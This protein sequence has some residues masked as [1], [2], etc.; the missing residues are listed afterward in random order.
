MRIAC[1][2]STRPELKDAVAESSA[3]VIS[4]LEGAAADLTL[5]F[6]SHHHR[7]QFP[8][9]AAAWQ[10]AVPTR[11][12]LGCSGEAIVAGR[13]EV[14]GGPCLSA[15]TASCPQTELVPFRVEFEPTPDGVVCVGLPE[16]LADQPQRVRAVILLG[17]PFSSA[18]RS[19]LD[20]LGDE[21]PGVP[22]VGGMASGG[23]PDENSLFFGDTAVPHGA[24]GVALLDAP[25][26]ITL[27][28]QGC[29][30]IGSPYIVTKSERNVIYELGGRPAMERLQELYPT[31]SARDQAL[32]EQGLH[33]GLAM[34]EYQDRFGRGDFLVSN[35]MGAHR[36]SGAILLGNLV[37]TGQ[38]VQFHVRD[39]E[40]ADEDLQHLLEALP[41]P[42]SLAGGLLFTC[43]GRGTRM[44]STPDHDAAAIQRQL[45]PLPLA[46]LFAAGEIG[47]VG[48]R[49]YVH[50]FTA[51]VALFER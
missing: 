21:L 12:L 20:R 50:G 18:P 41:K 26:V 19:V 49:N 9:V 36:E 31:L 34:S 33:V 28:S 4:G 17:E 2:A 30:P 23:G 40:T 7:G 46:G 1:G 8:A 11:C 43:N 5:L 32:I 39:A 35:V 45:G 47:P 25:R 14:E 51:S 27:V 29:K 24:V 44:F 22:V 16:Q 42:S 48:G 10:R 3:S 38:T 6:V 13:R 15:W 37:R